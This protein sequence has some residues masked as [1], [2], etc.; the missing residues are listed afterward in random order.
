MNS[1]CVVSRDLFLTGSWHQNVALLGEQLL[2]G[3]VIWSGFWETLDGL[4]G[5]LVLFELLG[6]NAL[7]GIPDGAIVLQDTDKSST[8]SGE[9]SARVETDVTE[10]LK[11]NNKN[12][13]FNFSL[14]QYVNINNNN[15]KYLNNESLSS[16]ARLQTNQA[17]VMSI[18]D[19]VVNTVVQ[20]LL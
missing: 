5:N 13:S 20:T 14:N 16:K 17:H 2:N 11:L 15:K 8:V 9:I 19:K 10:T 18:I 3:L 4:V 7:F 6:V 12:H 1:A